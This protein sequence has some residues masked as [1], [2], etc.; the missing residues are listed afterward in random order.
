LVRFGKVDDLVASS[1]L[2]LNASLAAVYG[3]PG[4]TG[5]QL[6]ALDV[7]LPERSH[8]ILS[9]PA[10]LAAFARPDRGDPVH[11]GLFLYRALLCE[12][13]LP[14]PPPSVPDVAALFPQGATERQLSQLRL[15]NPTC[16]MCHVRVDPLGLLSERYDAIGR[17]H[18]SDAAGPI[19]E[20]ATLAMLGAELDGP[21]QGLAGL[22]DKLIGGRRLSDC[23]VQNLS[24]MTL[25]RQ[26]LADDQSCALQAVKDAL[27]SSRKLPDFYRALANS[28]A[29][30]TR[31]AE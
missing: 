22:A 15:D 9:Q 29:F 30:I 1:R 23:V 5:S 3:V 2:Y 16:S 11:R 24:A 13:E 7:A 20:S 14:P 31:D 25:G 6:R 21:T 12:R 10:M 26:D 28:P 19:D 17:Y 4:V 27:A 18:A 8:G